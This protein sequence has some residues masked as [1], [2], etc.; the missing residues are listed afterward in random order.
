MAAVIS[1]PI[2]SAVLPDGGQLELI[3]SGEK[4]TLLLR[5]HDGRAVKC[6]EFQSGGRRFTPAAIG[7]AL[8][9]EIILATGI[10]DYKSPEDL[11]NGIGLVFQSTR[12]LD[13]NNAERTTCFAFATHFAEF[14]DPAPRA[15]VNGIDAWEILQF[16]ELLA[17]FCRHAIRTTRFEPADCWNLPAGC[18]PTFLISDP[19]PSSALLKFLDATQHSGFAV[20][21]AGRVV[22]RPFSAV[23]LTSGHELDDRIPATFLRINATPQTRPSLVDAKALQKIAKDFQPQLL[24]YRLKNRSRVAGATFD[25]D[26]FRGGTRALASVLGSCFPNSVELQNRVVKLLEPQDERCRLDHARSESAVVLEALLIAC[27]EGRASVHV[28][29]IAG[30]ANG[31][32]DLRNDGYHLEARKVG[33]I[34]SSFSLGQRRDSRGYGFQL[35]TESKRRIHQLARSI[36]VPFFRGQIEKCDLC[37][38][39]SPDP[40]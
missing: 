24:A 2:A 37:K 36:D 16:L 20:K 11:F 17:P 23:V 22:T 25:A 6:R 13:R 31:I 33:N 3:R 28:G 27:H 39:L 5:W 10:S 34:L 8:P 26:S 4:T 14:R 40:P 30:L 7:E 32:L 18:S 35:S 21:Q 12:G 15:I 19:R 1:L 38:S 29:E 9:S